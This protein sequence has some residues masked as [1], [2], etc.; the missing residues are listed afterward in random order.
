MPIAHHEGLYFLP[1][2][3]LDRLKKENRVVFRYCSPDGALGDSWNPNGS[4][5]HIA[6][7][8]NENGNVLG[9]MPHPERAAEK[10]LG[11]QDGAFIWDSLRTW[12]DK[13]G[14]RR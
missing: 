1:E 2:N 11:S 5:D 3:D 6:G 7:I 10:I 13:G 12:L 4:L 9:L 14:C 8:V